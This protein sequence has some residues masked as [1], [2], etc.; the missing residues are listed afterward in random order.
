MV[1]NIVDKDPKSNGSRS[2]P[3]CSPVLTEA[4]EEKDF[5]IKTR[6]RLSEGKEINRLT[7]H[8]Q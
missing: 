4:A 1:D 2:E 6:R 5:A 8:Y 3:C 7:I